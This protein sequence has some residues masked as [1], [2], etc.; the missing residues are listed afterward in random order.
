MHHTDIPDGVMYDG[1]DDVWS[2]VYERHLSFSVKCAY[3]YS[4]SV[5]LSKGKRMIGGFE[6]SSADEAHSIVSR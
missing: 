3:T 4:E 1:F 5:L 2:V 6:H